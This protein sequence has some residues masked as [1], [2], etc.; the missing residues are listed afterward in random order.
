MQNIAAHEHALTV[1]ALD[2]LNGLSG[3]RII[4]PTDATDRGSALSFVV[5]GL[6]PHD[7]GQ[8]LD[9]HGVAVRV[10]HHCA[11]PLCRRFGV[12]AT[13]RATFYLYN[14]LADV[15]ALAEGIVAAQKFF[16]VA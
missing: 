12:P 11:W 4:G 3:I 14:E 13:T 16:K 8:V 15:D 5:E 10:G 9:A 2:A 1:A 6:H 7:V